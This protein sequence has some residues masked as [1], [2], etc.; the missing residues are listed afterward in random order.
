MQ[1]Y[2]TERVMILDDNDI[3]NFITQR[4]LN[5]S[6]FTK[7][8]DICNS[9]VELLEYLKRNEHH[10]D[11]IPEVIFVDLNMPVIKGF[12]FLFEFNA[13]SKALKDKCQIIVLSS[14]KE[15]L[16]VDK[17]LQ[18]EFVADFIAKPLT[19]SALKNMQRVRK[20]A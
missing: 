15:D 12:V 2:Q 3:D 9:G 5:K 17:V 13:L 18:N 7:Q 1:N 20:F 11:K 4:V 8:V 6:H 14:L 16:S 19:A 10:L